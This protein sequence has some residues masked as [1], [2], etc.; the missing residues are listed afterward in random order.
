MKSLIACCGID[1]ETC[2]AR[3]A[4]AANDNNLR[5]ETAKKWREMFNAPDITA[6]LI[7]CTGCRTEGA[8]FTQCNVCEIRKCATEKGFNTC[9]DCGELEICQTVGF[10]LQY[11]PEAK[12]N[13][14]G[15]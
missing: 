9:G 12:A 8:K 3:I 15:I 13:L 2:D 11:V 6:D 5:E 4:T 7:N 1:C 10:V 14:T